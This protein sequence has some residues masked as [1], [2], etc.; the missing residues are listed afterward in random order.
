MA[1]PA[2]RATAAAQSNPSVSS[3]AGIANAV[4]ASEFMAEANRAAHLAL[5]AVRQIAI[6]SFD[7]AVITR[8][9]RMKAVYAIQRDAASIRTQI[10]HI[11]AAMRKAAQAIEARRAETERL[12]AKHESA[13]HASEKE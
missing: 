1:L 3:K 11:E 10:E 12:G 4:D 5:R 7:H 13:V 8:Y 6:T 9:P 2:A